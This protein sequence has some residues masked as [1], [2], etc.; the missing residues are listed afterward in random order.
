MASPPT[1]AAARAHEKGLSQFIEP[2]HR[3]RFRDSLRDEKLRV[4]LRDRLAHFEWLDDR[5]AQD[6]GPLDAERVIGRLRSLGAPSTCFVVSE[7]DEL[8]GRFMPLRDAVTA[9]LWDDYGT[10]ISCVPGRLAF[11]IDEVRRDAALLVR[12]A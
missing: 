4:K 3:P 5:Y 12:P 11:Y 10:L 9:A 8:D 6:P 1:E 2:V 7:D